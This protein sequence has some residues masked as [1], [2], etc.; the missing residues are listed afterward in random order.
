MA[1]LRAFGRTTHQGKCCCLQRPF[2]KPPCAW[3]R[4]QSRQEP[5]SVR[6]RN[7]SQCPEHPVARCKNTTVVV[8]LVARM[9]ETAKGVVPQVVKLCQGWQELRLSLVATLHF[10]EE[11]RLLT[12]H[13]R[14]EKRPAT[15]APAERGAGE[16]HI[17]SFNRVCRRAWCKIER[18]QMLHTEARPGWH[19]CASD[20]LLVLEPHNELQLSERWNRSD[21]AL[22]MPCEL[23]EQ[24]PESK[25]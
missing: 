23:H 13:A 6:T 2:R 9:C 1:V 16:R 18:R 20:P 12:R 8:D 11:L 24:K 17:R 19:T 21:P 4:P 22:D 3:A 14:S 7:N 25:D 5:M 15:L 10:L